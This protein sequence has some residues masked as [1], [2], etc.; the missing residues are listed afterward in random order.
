[1]TRKHLIL[2]LLAGSLALTA[3]SVDEDFSDS[4]FT[5]AKDNYANLNYSGFWTFTNGNETLRSKV[6]TTVS[7]IHDTQTLT[8]WSMPNDLIRQITGWE[9]TATDYAQ[10]DWAC[11]TTLQAKGNSNTTWVYALNLKDYIFPFM[12]ED[13]KHMMKVVFG[14]AS[15]MAYDTYAQIITLMLSIKEIYLDDQLVANNSG[16]LVLEATSTTKSQEEQQ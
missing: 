10:Y 5:E 13:K 8:L 3:C 2:G 11:R 15:E 6:S 7:F 4:S 1:M 14:S 12:Q 9:G 16:T